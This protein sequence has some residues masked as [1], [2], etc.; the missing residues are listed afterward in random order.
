STKHF[1]LEHC[2]CQM[3]PPHAG[4]EKSMIPSFLGL[5]VVAAAVAGCVNAAA[6]TAAESGVMSAAVLDAENGSGVAEIG[7]LP[8]ETASF[9]SD[10]KIVDLLQRKVEGCLLTVHHLVASGM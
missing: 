4:S 1:T 6:T 7:G 10:G 5:W 8:G 3:W 2:C 9:D